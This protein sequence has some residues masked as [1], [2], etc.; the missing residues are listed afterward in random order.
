M[1]RPSLWFH[2]LVARAG[3]QTANVALM[4]VKLTCANAAAW[5]QVSLVAFGDSSST[6][7]FIREDGLAAVAR[8]NALSQGSSCSIRSRSVPRAMTLPLAIAVILSQVV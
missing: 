1:I 8:E 2:L 4:P 5:H 6:S 3:G 7:D